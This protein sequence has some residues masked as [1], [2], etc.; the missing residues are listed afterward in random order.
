MGSAELPDSVLRELDYFAGLNRE[1]GPL[2]WKDLDRFKQELN[3]GPTRRIW[4]NVDLASLNEA[5]STRGIL[6]QDSEKIVGI[7]E[8]VKGGHHFRTRL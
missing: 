4:S 6:P 2:D 3:V 5:C 1:Y 7:V 8:R